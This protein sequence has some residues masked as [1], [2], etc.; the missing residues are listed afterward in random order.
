MTHIEQFI[1]DAIEGGWQYAQGRQLMIVNG[2]LFLVDTVNPPFGVTRNTTEPIN[3]HTI[4]TFLL[5]KDAWIAAS[6]TR[7]WNQGEGSGCPACGDQMSVDWRYYMHDFI[8]SIAIG[9]S[10][11]EA[12][13]AISK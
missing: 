12:L 3:N 10:I 8:E 7:D 13:A 4:A 1:K 5:D 2:D 9:K 6:K 11:E